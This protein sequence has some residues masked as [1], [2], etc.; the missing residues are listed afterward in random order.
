MRTVRTIL[1]VFVAAAALRAQPAAK[2]PSAV[3]SWQDLL[4][5][6]NSAV[7]TLTEAIDSTQLTI[8]VTNG[9]V[10]AAP[11][12]IT[13]DAEHILICSI[14]ANTLNV[15]SGGRGFDSSSATSHASGATVEGRIL[16]RHHEQLAAEVLALETNLG[17]NLTGVVK[18]GG[19]TTASSVPYVT[20]SGT[21]GQDTNLRWSSGHFL[22]GTS[23][24][25]GFSR[26]RVAGGPI[27]IDNNQPYRAQDSAGAAVGIL[28]LWNTN[29]VMVG[30]MSALPTNGHLLFA[31][32]GVEKMRLGPDGKLG[33]GTTSPT[34][35]GTGLL[36]VAS[37]TARPF[38]A[39][40]TPAS[41]SEAC[42]AGE[43]AFDA[44]YLYLCVASN[45]WKRVALSAF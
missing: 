41:S 28:R 6:K 5:A 24:D 4:R 32:N 45:T 44:G 27:T 8:P 14:T 18:N 33:L 9:S 10:F 7:S 22:I 31:A 21:L 40:R 34:V 15:C 23:I 30:A 43:I 20:A 3:A 37:N 26:L 2:F 42:N 36:H 17:A 16:A 25:D 39:T 11:G 13:I 12:A 19:L 1:L 35:S 29:M 38:D